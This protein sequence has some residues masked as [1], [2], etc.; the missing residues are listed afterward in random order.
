MKNGKLRIAVAGL[1]FGGSFVPIWC[2]H[3]D[4]YQV[5]VIEINGNL[6]KNL[7]ARSPGIG[8]KEV[9]HSL[10]D[11]L[12]EPEIDAVH[13]V[14]PIPVHGN[15]TLQV[16]R[17]GKHCA[18]AVPAAVTL[19]E[20]FEIVQAQK[21]TGKNYMMMETAAYTF[22]LLHVEKMIKDGEFGR[23]QMLRGCHYQDMEHWPSY[24]NGLPP[25]HYA[26]HAISPLLKLANTRAAEVVCFGTGTMRDELHKQYGN[27]YPAE[28]ALFKLADSP[29]I[30]EVTRTLFETAKCSCEGFSVYGSRKTFEWNIGEEGHFEAFSDS[31]NSYGRG[32]FVRLEQAVN[33]PDT[34]NM[35]P[36]EI[37]RFT[38]PCD[39]DEKNPQAT[40]RTGGGHHG[41][42]PHLVHEFARSIMENRLPAIDAV[43]AAQW[44]AA[45]ICAHQSAMND[46]SRVII[47]AFA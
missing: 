23:I 19:E 16:L 10:E 24:W 40:F 7:L 46:G 3:P 26:T 21:E 47:P 32:N 41:S 18:C 11:A 39:Y 37:G 38:V 6:I 13:I 33:H 12:K 28:T 25:M 8:V 27:P 17:S 44:T 15:Q 36:P 22:P 35:L 20:L 31:K 1:G 29:A 14:T 4:V 34:G 2:K 42:H 43:K 45:G 30:L 5:D 9:Y